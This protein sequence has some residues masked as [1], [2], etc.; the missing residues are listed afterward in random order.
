MTIRM[1][2]TGLRVLVGLLIVALASRPLAAQDAA[3]FRGDLAHTGVY[4][5][6]ALRSAPKVKWSFHTDGYVI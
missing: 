3:R 6:P 1:F 4:A 2:A 5:G